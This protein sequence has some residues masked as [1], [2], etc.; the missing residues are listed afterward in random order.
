LHQDN[1]VVYNKLV[2]VN[3]VWKILGQD[4]TR[5]LSPLSQWEVAMDLELVKQRAF[6]NLSKRK[7]HRRRETGFIYNHGE[8]TAKLVINLRKL[9]LPEDASMDEILQVAAF[10]HDVAKGIEPHSQ[11]G[12]ILAK[13]MLQDLCSSEELEKIAELISLH[14]SRKKGGSDDY[15]KLLQD[16]DLLDHFGSI[17]LWMGINYAANEDWNIKALIDFYKGEFAEIAAKN[18]SLLNF[19]ICER[20][21]DEKID[22]VHKFVRRL[23]AE[24]NGEI[25]SLDNM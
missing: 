21:F 16:A 6:E 7:A 1:D 19:E 17:E 2:R 10:F 18:R 22:F 24:N 13:E 8:R 14:T 15:A 3:I 20:I 25:V 5:N 4:G 11:Y 12:S 9:V 23:E